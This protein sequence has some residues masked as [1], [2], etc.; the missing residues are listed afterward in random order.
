MNTF[1]YMNMELRYSDNRITITSGTINEIKSVIKQMENTKGIMQIEVKKLTSKAAV[2]LFQA[3]KKRNAM[4]DEFQQRFMLVNISSLVTTISEETRTLFQRYQLGKMDTPLHDAT[5]KILEDE[6]VNWIE[7]LYLFNQASEK[8]LNQLEKIILD[9]QEKSNREATETFTK[10][11]LK[12]TQ[13]INNLEQTQMD[14]STLY[15]KC[16]NPITYF[17]KPYLSW[18]PN[19]SF[20]RNLVWEEE[21]KV[22]FIESVIEGIPIGVFFINMCEYFEDNTIGEGY[23]AVLWD[24]KQRAHAMH[25]FFEDEFKVNVGGRKLY[26]SQAKE[27]FYNVFS[28]YTAAV[29]VSRFETLEELIHAYIRI[30]K[31]QYG[32][33]ET[34]FEKAYAHLSKVTASK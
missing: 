18:N 14:L 5:R 27:F 4:F 32:H 20:Q 30:N 15:D 1:S 22:S 21:K 26:Y 7:C 29:Y 25:A 17:F 6:Q 10:E 33:T 3:V 28:H 8:H 16:F 19:P 2:L 34:D 13:Y 31:Q 11:D 9:V 12:G 24:G 23:G